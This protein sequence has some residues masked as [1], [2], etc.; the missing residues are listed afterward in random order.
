MN[1]LSDIN[2]SFSEREFINTSYYRNKGSLNKLPD[3]IIKDI[4][5]YLYY[6]DSYNIN[7]LDRDFNSRYPKRYLESIS[8]KK[9]Y[10]GKIENKFPYSREIMTWRDGK[11]HGEFTRYI[12]NNNTNI[13]YLQDKGNYNK[14]LSEGKWI[15]YYLNG[16]ISSKQ[17][18]KDGEVNGKYISYGIDGK[19]N[20]TGNYCRGR[21][22]GVFKIYEKCKL[23]SCIEYKNGIE[24]NSKVF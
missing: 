23:Y 2:V 8:V 4:I 16:F 11:Q 22:D 19:I 24:V 6:I 17:Y 9:E 21:R 13:E 12:Y 7:L 5:S 15:V 1:F 3:V 10:H 18:Y 20:Y 14:G